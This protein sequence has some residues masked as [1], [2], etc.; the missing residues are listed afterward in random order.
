RSRA[1]LSSPKIV[2][3]TH[4]ASF[5]LRATYPVS[6]ERSARVRSIWGRTPFLS[7]RRIASSRAEAASSRARPAEAP[8]R[9]RRAHSHAKRGSRSAH[10]ANGLEARAVGLVGLAPTSQ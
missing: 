1:L 9:G 4:G 6:S 3:P 10:E 7:Y 2:E 5:L 8:R